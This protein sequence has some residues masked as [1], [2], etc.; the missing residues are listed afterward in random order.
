MAV[1]AALA[2]KE[3]GITYLGEKLSHI[4]PTKGNTKALIIVDITII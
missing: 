1:V 4:Y 2:T 3:N